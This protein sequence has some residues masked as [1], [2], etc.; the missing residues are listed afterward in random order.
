MCGF[1]V[2]LIVRFLYNWLSLEQINV[3]LREVFF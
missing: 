2:S 1:A 3:L